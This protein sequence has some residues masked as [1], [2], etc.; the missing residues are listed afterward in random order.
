MLTTQNGT[1]A[2]V[3]LLAL[4]GTTTEATPQFARTFRVDC[5]YC[6]SAPPRLNETGIRFVTAGYRLDELRTTFSTPPVAVWNT[7]DGEG[8]HAIDLVKG[9]PSRVEIISG[10]RLGSG[11]YFAEWRALSL[12]LGGN[13]R[14]LNR[15]GRFEDLFVRLPVTRAGALSLTAGQFR[16]LTQVDVSLR[17]SLSEPLLFSSGVPG[18]VPARS[19]RLTALRAFSASGRQPGFRLEYQSS[20]ADALSSWLVAATLPL[21][22]ELTIPLTEAASFELEA[23]PKGIFV[24]SFRRWGLTSLGGHVFV[25]DGR[26]RI[27]T[28]VATHVVGDRITMLA[29][30]GAFHASS[31]TDTRFSAGAELTV[32]RHLVGGLRVDHRTRQSRDPAVLLYGNV[33]LPFGTP[34]FRQAVRFQIEQRIQTGAHATVAALS[35]VF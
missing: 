19:A 2:A 12:S 26:R 29:G 33:H 10:G 14:I 6:H 23:R 21:A 35:H 7:M 18:P 8:R 5:A 25:G 13:G 24:E 11:S 4:G 32:S 27:A 17:L 3:C 30:V 22:G 31:A 28:L 15:S 34:A 9:F 20:P 1:A 16:T